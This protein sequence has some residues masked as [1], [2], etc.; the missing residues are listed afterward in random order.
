M[1]KPNLQSYGVVIGGA[2]FFLVLFFIVSLV[3]GYEPYADHSTAF[4]VLKTVLG[5]LALFGF[6]SF[7]IV[8]FG[9][10]SNLITSG[11]FLGI[12]VG[13][14]I[15]ISLSAIFAFTTTGPRTTTLDGVSI[16]TVQE[17]QEF[18]LGGASKQEVTG[19]LAQYKPLYEKRCKACHSLQSI[20][21]N[22]VSKYVSKGKT[23]F[24]VNWMAGMPNSGIQP[25]EVDNI[26]A[27]INA[28]YG[29]GGSSEAPAEEAEVA[30]AG[31]AD[32]AE[33]PTEEEAPAEEASEAAPLDV[34]ALQAELENWDTL[35]GEA[36]YKQSCAACHDNGMGGAAPVTGDGSTWTGRMEQGVETM[37]KKS[38]EGFGMM[39]ARGG[40]S[41]LTDKQVGDAVAYMVEES[42]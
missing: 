28:L 19:E 38:I 27:Y 16:R 7:M 34:A 24:V 12:L 6:A 14:V 20:E 40:N 4:G 22:L 10:M 13:A 15:M 29:G 33:A 32:A 3:T 39:P 8:I 11:W 17:L 41:A 9:K 36:I 25:T 42:L 37:V 2:L 26:I 21:G 1:D 31:G 5:W 35:E 30:D 18:K 23:D